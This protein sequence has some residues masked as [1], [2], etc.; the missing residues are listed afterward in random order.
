MKIESVSIKRLQIPLIR[1]F[2]TAV[3]QT[4]HVDDV[5][6]MIKTTCGKIG[7]GSA[8]STPA[9]TG[10]TTESIIAAIKDIIAPKLIGKSINEFENLISLS[11]KALENNS[12]PK[13]AIDIAL[14]DLFAQKSQMP[15]YKMLGGSNNKIN[16]CITI[17]VKKPS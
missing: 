11:D 17:S 15:L 12:S 2:I 7:Y 8:A 5:V 16:T 9:I 6:V 10:D 14:H 13:A 1:P 4:S 3:R